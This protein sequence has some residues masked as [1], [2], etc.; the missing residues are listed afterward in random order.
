MNKTALILGS[1][2]LVGSIL[3]QKL[4]NHSSYQH[5]IIVVRKSQQIVHP[6]L[7]EIVTDFNSP[8]SWE[9][10]PK[11]DSIFSCLGTTR[12]KTPDLANYR[13]IEIEIPLQFCTIGLKQN[14]QK[15]H[16]ISSVGAN[17]ESRNFYLK[18]KGEAEHELIKQGIPHLYLYRP[19][20]LIGNRKET[21]FGEDIGKFFAPLFNFLMIGALSKYK[22]M[23]VEHLAES[24]IQYDLEETDKN[25][26]IFAFREIMKN[27]KST[28]L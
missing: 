2:G 3:L 26:S 17:K 25:L 4:L 5:I 24:I 1:S 19:S 18:M 22:S 12:N 14:L 21:R 8:I 6:K 7:I 23:K 16:Y 9:N 11:I 15:F 27:T 28:S 20:L 13:K 10:F